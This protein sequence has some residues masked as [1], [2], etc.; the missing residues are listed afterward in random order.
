ML[1]RRPSGGPGGHAAVFEDDGKVAY[2]Y[3]LE[4][5]RI[6]ADVWLYNRAAAP[7]TPEWRDPTAAPFANPRGFAS[8]EHFAPVADESE[9]EFSW[10][11]GP[12]EQTVLRVIIRGEYH[13][14]LVPGSKPGWCRLAIKNGPLALPLREDEGLER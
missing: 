1:I 8:D 5:G 10:S 2:A 11:D 3:L 12:D 4:E 7:E 9:V 13:A 14:R 6:V